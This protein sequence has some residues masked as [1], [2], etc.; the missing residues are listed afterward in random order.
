MPF[1]K[2]TTPNLPST[3]FSLAYNYQ[4]R[5]EYTRNIFSG[6]YGYTWSSARNLRFSVKVPNVSIIK[7]FN[8]DPDFYSN[9]NSSYLQYLYQDHFDMGMN[10]SVYYTTNTNVN[11]TVSYF[12]L[13]GDLASS[14][15]GLSLLNSYMD[16][17]RR[18]QHIIWGIP[19]SQYV[20]TQVTA[21]GTLRFG[22]DNKMALAA[23]FL[24]GVGY[25]YGNSLF[26]MP[27][28]QMFYAGGASSMRGWQS[29]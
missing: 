9:L 14:G 5:P 19:Y 17:N 11:P 18:G 4:N 8:I 28:E 29:R 10:A 23:R 3:D 24:G 6:S 12:Y 7:I 22:R 25:A 13:R 2:S 27:M 15:L 20:R 16:E 21:V 1:I 26:S